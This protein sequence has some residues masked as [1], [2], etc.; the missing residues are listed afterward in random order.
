MQPESI[1]ERAL[2]AAGEAARSALAVPGRLSPGARVIAAMSGGVDS[3]VAAGLLCGAGFDVVGVSM[4]LAP[5]GRRDEGHTGCCSLDDFEDARRVARVLGI[6]HYVVDLR[7]VFSRRVIDAFGDSYLAGE[8]PNPCT[9]CNR[10]V[11]LGVFRDYAATMGAQAVATGHYARV[12]EEPGGMLALRAAQD[13]GK[14]QSYFLFTLDQQELASTLFPLGDLDKQA[15]RAV[16]RALELPVAE[17]AESQDVCFVAGEGYA[18]FVERAT[19]PARWRP[20]RI[21]DEEGAELGRHGGIHRFTV[22]Q[23]RGLPGGGPEPRY[24]LGIDA[25]SGDVRVGPRGSLARTG[26]RARD[27]CWTARPHRGQARVRLRHRHEPV[28]CS[29][30]PAGDGAWVRFASPTIGVTPGQAA[31]WYD[32]DRVVGGGWITEAEA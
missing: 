21:V 19:D 25:A 20:G 23:R 22:G 13:P 29:V 4:R 27:V 14:D 32:G 2:A 9:L 7:E 1:R 12:T 24:V 15:V 8:T 3:S 26:F 10:D 6:P 5:S 30:E 28:A 16:A 17:K 18:D 11:K 31:V